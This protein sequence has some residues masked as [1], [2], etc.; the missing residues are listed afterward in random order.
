VHEKVIA[1]IFI[2]KSNIGRVGGDIREK[3][4]RF[5]RLRWPTQS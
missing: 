1:Q 5:G 2:N 4:G 3:E